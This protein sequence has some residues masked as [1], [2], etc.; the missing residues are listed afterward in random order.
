MV[1]YVYVLKSCKYNRIYI[2]ISE[3]PLK[4]LE[5]HNS[6]MTKSTKFYKPYKVIY[7]EKHYNRLEARL[8]EKYLKSGEGRELI[9]SNFMGR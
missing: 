6:G 3:D 5:E 1:Y 8:R 4:R 9:K 7:Q 2:G